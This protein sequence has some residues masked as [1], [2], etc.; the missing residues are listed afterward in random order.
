M[1]NSDKVAK[2]DWNRLLGFEQILDA[3]E[4]VK[5][6]RLSVKVGQKMGQK[7]GQKTGGKN[8]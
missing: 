7:L 3:R 4:A 2:L 5:N 6:S 1:G 8:L